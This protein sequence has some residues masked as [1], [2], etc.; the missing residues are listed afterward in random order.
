MLDA[1]AGAEEMEEGDEALGVTAGALEIE[2]VEE[3]GDGVGAVAVDGV[4]DV[5][6][7]AEE[8]EEGDE[9]LGVGAVAVD[10]VLSEGEEEEGET[11]G[12]VTIGEDD[13]GATAGAAVTDVQA[14]NPRPQ[15]EKANIDV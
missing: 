1:N 7:G 12:V 10:G 13:A 14:D 2:E 4:L 3:E 5:T 11:V 15:P 6:A 9:S 8:E